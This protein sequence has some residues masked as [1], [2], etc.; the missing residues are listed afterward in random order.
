MVVVDG[1]LG[2]E[3]LYD[4]TRQDAWYGEKVGDPGVDGHVGGWTAVAANWQL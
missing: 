1:P 3:G 4:M 2:T